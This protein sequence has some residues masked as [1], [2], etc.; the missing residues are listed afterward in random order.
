MISLDISILY[1]VILFVLLWLVLNKIL[2]QPYLRLLSERE[3][4]TTGAQ[5]DSTEL[6]HEAARLRIQYEEKIAQAHSAASAERERILQLARQDR[7]KTLS[8]ARREAEQ[9]LERVRG[10]IVAAL[11][12]EKRL[13]SAE[14]AGIAGDI[15]SKVL[16]RKVA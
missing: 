16:G 9:T 1:Q 11:E 2:F 5:H 6:E 3:Q 12:V 14:A 7:E 8:Q 4:K 13:A 15:A 10:E